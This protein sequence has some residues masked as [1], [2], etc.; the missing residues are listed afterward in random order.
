MHLQAQASAPIHRSEGSCVH[1]RCSHRFSGT[2]SIPS[3]RRIS[4]RS[5]FCSGNLF[6]I[7]SRSSSDSQFFRFDS[8]R[9]DVSREVVTSNRLHLAV[10]PTSCRLA[11]FAIDPPMLDDFTFVLWKFFYSYVY[12]LFSIRSRA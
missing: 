7:R 1:V 9:F 4:H 3:P 10:L 8:A 12:L 6:A 5:R 11:S 2:I